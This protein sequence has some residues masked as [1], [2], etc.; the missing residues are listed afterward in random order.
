MTVS[1]LKINNIYNEDCFK[2]MGKMND[3]FVNIILTS[4]P[5]NTSRTPKN[6]KNMEHLLKTHQTRYDVYTDTFTDDEYIAFTLKLFNE[7]DRIVSKNGVVLYN[8][9]YSS[10]NTY[11]IWLVVA[12]IIKNTNWTVADD[13]I[14]KK[15]SALP[16]NVSPNKLT[17]IVEHI[18]VFC[19]K[20]EFKT[21]NC[22]KK[23]KSVRKTGQKSFENIFNFIE[24]PNNDGRN[25]L[26]KATYSTELCEKILTIY[27]K[28][29]SLIYDPFNGTGTTC[30]D[31]KK[32]NLNYIGSELSEA[33]CEYAI[34]RVEKT[35][36]KIKETE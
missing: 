36:N 23:V 31:C 30:V 17:R 19:R 21:F 10:E 15:K 11:L 14:W 18:F 12:E 20:N 32:L 5:Y 35:S 24:A 26:N 8:L 33:Q 27:A 13:I 1:N 7:F 29:G 2:T 3:G 16:N 4:P 34:N 22:N 25:D 6:K 28:D 9:S